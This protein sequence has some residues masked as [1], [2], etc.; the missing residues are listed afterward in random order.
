MRTMTGDPAP[1]RLADRTAADLV[2]GVSPVLDVPFLDTGE[3]DL[4]GFEA[5]VRHVLDTGVSSVMFPGFASEFH[6]LHE[7]ERADL[8]SILLRHTTPREDVAAII[9]VQDHA[10]TLAVRRAQSV[11]EQGA[12]AINLLP[13]YFLAPPARAVAEHVGTVLAAVAPTPVILQYAP[14]E[15]GTSL[16]AGMLT[17]LAQ[18]HENLAM[19][20]VESSPPGDLIAQLA[21]GRPALPAM[22]GYA[23]VQLPDA[24]RRGAV[25]TQPGCSFTEIYQA[26]W[27]HFAAGELAV[28]DALHRRLLPF[29]SYWMLNTELIIAAE[30]HISM[31][32]GLFASDH[33]RAPAHRL[34]AEELR[35]IDRFFVEF[36]DLLPVLNR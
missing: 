22:E 11:I 18:Q 19:V 2:R 23:G 33:C 6:K 3:V 29:I 14:N 34:D 26:I 25:G 31:R 17:R 35:M 16:D 15:T 8:T 10:T 21:G 12:D 27:A 9:A 28:G 1:Q 5:V 36:D 20:K 7:D 4:A 30:K 24:F 13:P 32:R